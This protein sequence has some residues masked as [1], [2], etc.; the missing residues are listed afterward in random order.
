MRRS[1]E[2]WIT[3][4][5]KMPVRR[6][7]VE[8]LSY[9]DRFTI[10]FSSRMGI[11]LSVEYFGVEPDEFYEWCVQHD[12]R[13]RGTTVETF[14]EG[15]WAENGE[16]NFRAYNKG[17]RI[18]SSSGYGKNWHPWETTQKARIRI[19]ESAITLIT[20]AGIYTREE[21]KIKDA[22]D[23]EY[24]KTKY[25]R[26]IE[27]SKSFGVGGDKRYTLNLLL[28]A[29]EQDGVLKREDWVSNPG[30]KKIW[31]SVMNKEFECS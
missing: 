11:P 15:L 27:I 17:F 2:K 8:D 18:K 3:R 28:W 9:P 24:M 29:I 21:E 26:E 1:A 30:L 13:K 22:S 5:A 4:L 20:H 16:I 10:S 6:I 19:T 25:D 23:I 31:D 12:V 14:E 7:Y